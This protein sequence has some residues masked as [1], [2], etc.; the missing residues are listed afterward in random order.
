MNIS[1]DSNCPISKDKIEKYESFIQKLDDPINKSYLPN[2][3]CVLLQASFEVDENKEKFSIDNQSLFTGQL[4]SKFINEGWAIIGCF[5]RAAFLSN[6]HHIRAA[7]EL[8]ATYNWV[9]YKNNKIERRINKYFEFMDLFSYQLYLKYGDNKSSE[10]L[11]FFKNINIEKINSWKA[12]EEFWMK[13]YSLRNNDLSEIKNWHYPASIENILN[14]FSNKKLKMFYEEFSHGTHL[15]PYSHSLG[16]DDT[17][18]GL[19]IGID[20]DLSDINRPLVIYLESFEFLLSC[21]EK[22][23]SFNSKIKFPIIN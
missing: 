8:I 5:E 21:I 22:V 12:K 17:I 19:P 20:G 2:L 4:L 13:L 6:Y 3:Y 7:L 9:F 23:K 10:Y 16:T 18:L 1:L 14:E 11:P 15:S